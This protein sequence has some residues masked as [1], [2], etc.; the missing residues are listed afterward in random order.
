MLSRIRHSRVGLSRTESLLVLAAI[1]IV[2]LMAIDVLSQPVE[3]DVALYAVT[4]VQA[5]MDR[6]EMELEQGDERVQPSVSEAN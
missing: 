6:I 4:P 2:T 3:N 1:G 5:S